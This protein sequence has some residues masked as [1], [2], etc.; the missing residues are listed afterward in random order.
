MKTVVKLTF[1]SLLF[2][3]LQ[4]KSQDSYIVVRIKGKV[5][6]FKTG[7]R[8]KSGDV[9]Q[10]TDKITFDNFDS[11]IISIS[12]NTGRYMIKL[13]EPPV[14]EVTKFT[15][16]VRDIAIP[17]KRR[18]LMTERYRPDQQV[19]DDLRL[20]F[21]NGKFSVIG[22]KI[23]IPLD[24]Q[25]IPVNENRFVVFYYR[26]NNSPISKKIG[27]QQNVLILEKDKLIS[28]S[29]GN[30]TSDEIPGVSVYLYEPET[31]SSDKIAK[32]DLV[33]VDPD[34]LTREFHTILPILKSQN[35][36]KEDIKK[37]LIEYYYDFYGA[38]DSRSI[39][40][41]VEQIVNEA[42]K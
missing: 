21:G 12:Q 33:F 26:V 41:F 35:M 5:T 40:G 7:T 31:R 37:Y 23:E 39:S 13:H 15:A 28:T 22:D 1:I 38:T 19:V 11:Y 25:R 20:Y 18:S 6:N 30:I 2:L 42:F 4:V 29:A 17:T 3:S 36:G 14:P 24:P 9:L 8:L 27:Y 32:F 34:Q 10:P 16:I